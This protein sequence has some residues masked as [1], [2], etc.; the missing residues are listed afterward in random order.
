MDKVEHRST[1]L[2]TI[3]D[4]LCTIDK[5]PCHPKNELFLYHRYVLS[6]ISCHLTIAD[7][8][9]T[10]IIE[11]LDNKVADYVHWWF[12][13]PISATLSNLISAN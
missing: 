12:E 11:H 7:L 8:C 3:S 2:E 4:L 9:K 10:C 6:K 1:L 13:L 5:I